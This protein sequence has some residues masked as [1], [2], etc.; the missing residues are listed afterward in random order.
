MKRK[1]AELI[2]DYDL[3]PRTSLDAANVS[4]LRESIRAGSELPPVIIDKKSK[5]V[6][7]GFHRIKALIAENGEGATIE[8]EERAYKN[9]KA[10]FLDAVRLNSGHGA[11]L[12]RHD[13]THCLIA[14]QR[15]SISESEMA[16]AL[17]MTVDK[18]AKLLVDRTATRGG[19][20]VPIKNT[21][22]HLRGS[23]LTKRQSDAMPKVGGMNQRF[24]VD[25]VIRLIDCDMLNTEDTALMERLRV[26]SA[27][28]SKELV[29]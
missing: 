3:Y 22:R 21:V 29:A 10:L 27:L 1:I 6:V 26:L 9:E 17:S 20:T 7:D 24:Y 5:R 19:L 13:A 12:H 28:L 4:Y 16:S 15:L 25:Q 2:L 14:G 23:R 18:A 11:K 8:V